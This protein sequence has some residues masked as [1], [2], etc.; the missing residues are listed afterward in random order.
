MFELM[1]AMRSYGNVYTRVCLDCTEIKT[2]KSDKSWKGGKIAGIS[3]RNG[4]AVSLVAER[5]KSARHTRE[6]RRAR[7]LNLF[8]IV[9][10]V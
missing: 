5:E 10:L 7:N 3:R 1:Y 9:K 8:R 6:S 2:F 4:K